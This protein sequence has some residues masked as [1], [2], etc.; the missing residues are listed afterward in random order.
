MVDISAGNSSRNA[1]VG[2]KSGLLEVPL[3]SQARKPDITMIRLII[4]KS[5]NFIHNLVEDNN[6][7]VETFEQN[8]LGLAIAQCEIQS[9]QTI[10]FNIIYKRGGFMSSK[11]FISAEEHLAKFDITAQQAKEFIFE[12]IEQREVLFFA[13]FDYS[14][15]TSMLS[16]ITGFSSSTISDYFAPEFGTNKLDNTSILINSDLGGLENLVA[17]NDNTE[18][19]STASLRENVQPLLN[20]PT[21][22]DFFLQP[23]GDFQTNDGIYDNEELGVA[24]L[25]NVAATNESIES[26][27]YGTL[28]NIFSTID[29]TELNQINSFPEDGNPGDLQVL[30]FD[31]LSDSPT[32][33]VWTNEELENL[34]TNEAA[35]IINE[36]V[37]TADV[38]GVLDLSFLG[39]SIA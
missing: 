12:N 33:I 10:A 34:V 22:Y 24:N 19:L 9:N 16:E 32:N 5:A 15:T 21:L 30:L 20:N 18:S 28:L 6:S 27:F 37:V 2:M 35:N 26:I 17:F 36:Y 1:A 23:P 11:Q 7:I 4:D 29:A 3:R 39:L 31:A 14:V 25:N 13:A 38:N 8:F